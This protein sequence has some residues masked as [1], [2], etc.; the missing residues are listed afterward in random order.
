MR[1][2]AMIT[3]AS[4]TSAMAAGEPER[5]VSWLTRV[6]TEDFKFQPN[7][8]S[9][10]DI[11][12][13]HD[14]EEGIFVLPEFKVTSNLPRG[15]EAAVESKRLAVEAE[16]FSWKH[17]GTILKLRSNVKLKFKYNPEHNGIDLL[18]ISW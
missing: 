13:A 18:S 4:V 2:L 10:L 14:P 16:K 5:S 9:A 6:L 15:L 12:E 3:L 11:M 7:Q 1:F 17:G 8:D